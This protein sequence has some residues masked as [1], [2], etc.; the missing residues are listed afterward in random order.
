MKMMM[1]KN[2][3]TTKLYNLFKYCSNIVI[4]PVK[5]FVVD[6]FF[7]IEDLIQVLL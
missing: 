6:K 5:K 2:F 7:L 3:L 1:E 4:V